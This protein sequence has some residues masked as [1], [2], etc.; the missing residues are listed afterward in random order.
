MKYLKYSLL[1]NCFHY[2]TMIIQRFCNTCKKL[3]IEYEKVL[4]VKETNEIYFRKHYCKEC[5]ACPKNPKHLTWRSLRN[6]KEYNDKLYC[7]ECKEY[8]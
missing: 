3:I 1:S 4:S 6:E 7:N 8:Y 5:N 2:P